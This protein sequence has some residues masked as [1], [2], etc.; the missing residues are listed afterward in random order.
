MRF[1]SAAIHGW[2]VSVVSSWKLLTSTTCTVSAVDA[3]TWLASGVPMLPPTSTRMPAASSIRPVSAVVVDF[4][5]VPVMATTRPRSHRD[6]SSTSP[7]T[8]TPAARAA[9]TEGW[10]TGTPGLTTTRSEPVNRR[11]GCEPSASET[12]SAAR[13]A[14]ASSA[15]RKSVSVTAAPRSTSRRAAATPL[16]APPTTATRCSAHRELAHLD[17]PPSRA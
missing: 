13:S 9:A 15:G 6:A 2:N 17:L 8:G 16:A 12:P 4:P 7:M 14:A 11:S 3:A 10:S 1:S 5:F